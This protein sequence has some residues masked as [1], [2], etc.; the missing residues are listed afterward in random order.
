MMLATLLG[1]PTLVMESQ[2]GVVVAEA[3]RWW[4]PTVVTAFPITYAEIVA[5]GAEPSVASHVTTWISTADA[6]HEA[7]VRELV[8]LG[9]HRVGGSWRPGSRYLD[10]LG[11]S[12]MG[13]A[14]FLNIH[15]PDTNTYNRCVG[16][17]EPIV[18]HAA[19]FDEDGAE[20]GVGEVG[21]LA[22]RTP[23]VTLGY[24]GD[25]ELTQKSIHKGYWLTGDVGYKDAKGRFYH[26]DRVTDVISTRRG[27]VYSLTLEEVI[28]KACRFVI[29]CAV[30]GAVDPVDPTEFEPIAVLR[31]IDSVTIT[32][33]ELLTRINK[34]LRKAG[35]H[36]IAA[37]VVASDNLQIPLGVTGK[38]LKRE[39]RS[40]FTNLLLAD[41]LQGAE[42]ARTR[43]EQF[44]IRQATNQV[45]ESVNGLRGKNKSVSA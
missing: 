12:E 5:L 8:R 40:A 29:D 26:Y 45:P 27:P 32:A 22:V 37:L 35:R 10:G 31:V 18:Q 11:A 30:V 39:V 9:R 25:Q 6:S 38:V 41:D 36:E 21:Y 7:H 1:L 44:I 43:S 17:P 2:A 3:M 14:L 15:G 42:I 28:F 33:D 16:Y 19:V 23:T 34:A 24:W 20:L 13:M 4:K